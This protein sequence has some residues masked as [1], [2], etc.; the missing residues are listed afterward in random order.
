M[1]IVELWKDSM[2]RRVD[3][4]AWLDSVMYGWKRNEYVFL[5]RARITQHSHSFYSYS[6]PFYSQNHGTTMSVVYHTLCSTYCINIFQ[7]CHVKY[8][9]GIFNLDRYPILYFIS[10]YWC[11][12]LHVN[13]SM[14]PQHV[15]ILQHHHWHYQQGSQTSDTCKRASTN[16]RQKLAET[17]RERDRA[18]H[19][20]K[21]QIA[22][23]TSSA[24]CVTKR[25]REH[26]ICH[27]RA[28]IWQFAVPDTFSR[29]ITVLGHSF[30]GWAFLEGG[31]Y[32]PHGRIVTPIEV[33][34][35]VVWVKQSRLRH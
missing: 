10:C 5:F 3:E 27:L 7:F 19:L 20:L 16:C 29:M 2:M 31:F 14:D 21:T 1:M 17:D 13:Y 8:D 34:G 11:S 35:G 6:K 33:R 24:S 26:V 9:C 25:H 30:G 15:Y 4:W 22:S 12:E 28:A 32:P 23:K 18:L